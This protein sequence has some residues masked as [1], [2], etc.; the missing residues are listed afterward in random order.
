[1]QEI[2]SSNPPVATGICDPNKSRARH[3]RKKNLIEIQ[4]K[5]IKL[6]F[7]HLSHRGLSLNNIN[8]FCL[9]LT[10]NIYTTLEEHK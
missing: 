7:S 5:E 1:M 9:F 8:I 2:R 4:K 10:N 3:H 6:T